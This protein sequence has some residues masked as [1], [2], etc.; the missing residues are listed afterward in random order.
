MRLGGRLRTAGDKFVTA[1]SVPESDLSPVTIATCVPLSVA[2]Q[3]PP[4]QQGRPRRHKK[5]AEF[6]V[7]Q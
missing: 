7:P 2:A 1:H 4:F 6:R 3:P 5:T